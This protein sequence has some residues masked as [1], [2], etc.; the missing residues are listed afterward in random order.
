M[1]TFWYGRRRSAS[2]LLAALVC[3]LA[4]SSAQAAPGD[5][6]PSFGSG[7]LVTT[8]FGGL[9][10]DSHSV[11]VQSDG[12]IVAGGFT[13]G[14]SCDFA[15]SRYNLDGSLDS[16]FGVDG[17]V[18]TA[19]PGE[20]TV[21]NAL[22]IGPDDKIVAVGPTFSSNFALA[23]YNPSGELDTTFGD[24]GRVVTDVASQDDATSVALQADGKIVLAG[25]TDGA[26]Y[27]DFILL[28][29]ETDGT[30]D[31]S[32]GNGGVVMTDFGAIDNANGLVIQKNQMIVA[33]GYT[34]GGSDTAADF[35]LARYNT[36]GSLDASFG[37]SGK[38]TTD[39]TFSADVVN[40]LTLQADGKIVAAG[41]TSGGQLGPAFALAR[42]EASGALDNSFGADGKVTT[43]FT[44][45]YRDDT[46]FAV[47]TQPDG[48]L[49]ATGSSGEPTF[50]PNKD[51]ALA[52]YDESGNL[53]HN[54]GT[55]GTVLT[56][57]GAD[58]VARALTL[59][60]DGKLVA[61]GFTSESAIGGDEKFALARYL[62]APAVGPTRCQRRTATLVGTNGDDV[63]TGTSHNDVITGLGGNDVI[64]GKGGND[65]ICGEQGRD[66][67]IGGLGSDSLTGG[68][69]N[70]D[71]DGG[72][73]ADFLNGNTGI[74]A[75]RNGE[76]VVNCE[77]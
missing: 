63:L 4:G 70:D 22:A 25:F 59:Q 18:I 58:D 44:D 35:A 62:A 69:G 64:D 43:D 19:F 75:C 72:R 73:G 15:L 40:A 77:A 20:L 39:F 51:F 60:T 56:N 7:G 50:P 31:G 24:G 14:P 6:D 26:T 41:V 61:A 33:A 1:R 3:L 13:C 34:N 49:V 66:T 47:L 10:D 37:D 45:T 28:R 54:F 52:R 57:F 27:Q 23:R 71:L 17:K 36:D 32:F 9:H 11:G 30:L 2:V 8:D 67:L 21:I 42:Y 68:R 38:V 53:D 29:Y 65:I 12:K 48:K 46:A 55:A 16:S 5:L 76:I 74:D